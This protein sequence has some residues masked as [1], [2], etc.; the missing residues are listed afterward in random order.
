[1]GC[2]CNKKTSLAA[3]VK[4]DKAASNYDGYQEFCIETGEASG[5][6]FRTL[7]EAKAV[8]SEGAYISIKYVK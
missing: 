5:P 1:M 3:I 8:K 4:E 6:C 7:E 2:G